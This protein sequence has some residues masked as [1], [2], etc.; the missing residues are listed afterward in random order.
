[1]VVFL[2]CIVRGHPLKRALLL[3]G[4]IG[5]MSNVWRQ[6]SLP[7]GM[8]IQQCVHIVPHVFLRSCKTDI[9]KAWK[10][11]LSVPHTEAL[12]LPIIVEQTTSEPTPI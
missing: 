9:K 3:G 4:D 6:V 1:M 7:L 11:L 5:V 2:R 12:A 10:R 8:R